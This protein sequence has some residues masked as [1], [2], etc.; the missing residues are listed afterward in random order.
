MIRS[1]F[2]SL[3]AALSLSTL[4]LGACA[5]T[6]DPAK[7]CTADWIK[8]RTARAVKEVKRE[9]GRTIKSLKK[10]AEKIAD[11]GMLAPYRAASMISSVQKL[12]DKIQNGRGVR[13]LKTLSATCDDPKIIRDGLVGY[14]ED[15]DAPKMLL[16][17]VRDF[18]FEKMTEQAKNAMEQ[19]Q[20]G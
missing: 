18:D 3:C 2:I 20:G 11:G 5:T 19:K 4:A 14:M 12:A 10:N 7:V 1:N 13:D 17:L 6:P 16:D 15:V 8:P 9:T